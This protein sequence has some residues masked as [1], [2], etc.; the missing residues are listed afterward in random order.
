M[1][2][3]K[4][5]KKCE[6]CQQKDYIPYTCKKCSRIVLFL[7]YSFATNI[8]GNILVLLISTIHQSTLVNQQIKKNI[9][10]LCNHAIKKYSP[11]IIFTVKN[12]TNFSV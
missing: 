6:I 11:S 5:G 10:A 7:I 8:I 12:A 3:D 1:Q 9:D 2:D 4:I